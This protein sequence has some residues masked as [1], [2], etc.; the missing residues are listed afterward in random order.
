MEL[1][2]QIGSGLSRI[3]KVYDRSV[4]EFTQSFTVVTFQFEK[5]F[6]SSNEGINERINEGIKSVLDVIKE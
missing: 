3:L 4:F 1:V 6:I 5:T 2:E